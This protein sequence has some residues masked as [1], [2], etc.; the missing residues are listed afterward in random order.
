MM[1]PVHFCCVHVGTL[2]CLFFP[3]E[4]E[5]Y[6]YESLYFVEP[7]FSPFDTMGKVFE[8]IRCVLGLFPLSSLLFIG[9]G[10]GGFCL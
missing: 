3:D 10:Y 4:S 7:L 2:L 5:A 8:A 1:K 6:F 9:Q